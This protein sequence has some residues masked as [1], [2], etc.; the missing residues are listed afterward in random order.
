MG[1]TGAP[2]TIRLG[3]RNLPFPSSVEY[4]RYMENFFGDIHLR[5]PCVEDSDFREVGARILATSVVQ[6]EDTYSLA[7][8]YVVFACCDVLLKTLPRAPGGPHGWSW[9]Q[10]ADDLLDKT[11]LL[12]GPGGLALIQVLLFQVGIPNHR[13]VHTLTIALGLVSEVCR[14]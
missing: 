2:I 7:L 4:N 12:T 14:H 8:N 13:G 10:V 5:Y 11:A 3:H 9:Y 6:P 1:S